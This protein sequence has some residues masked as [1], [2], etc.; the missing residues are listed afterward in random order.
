LTSAVVRIA[1]PELQRYL[2]RYPFA[3]GPNEEL[4]KQSLAVFKDSAE[5]HRSTEGEPGI[6]AAD[7]TSDSAWVGRATELLRL[8][9]PK[10]NVVSE[11]LTEYTWKVRGIPAGA[12][13]IL[14]IGCGDGCELAVIRAMFPD[15]S[16]DAIDWECKVAPGVQERLQVK[17]EQA[18]FIERL[19][20]ESRSYDAIFSNHVLEHMYDPET[21]LRGLLAWLSPGGAL[22]SAM[23]LDG[24]PDA[25]FAEAVAQALRTP[26][27]VS[28]IDLSWI[29][30]GHPWKA[31]P[32]SLRQILSA[33]GYQNIRLFERP[34][35]L[36]RFIVGNAARLRQVKRLGLLCDAATFA[37]P[38][39]ALRMWSWPPY[40]V[41]RVFFAAESRAWFS[42]GR[43]KNL[44]AP[45]ILF[46]AERPAN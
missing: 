39:A 15:A 16:I 43:L 13:R 21:T 9:R 45:E 42:R 33:A 38:R 20:S 3:T 32:I 18:S 10:Q 44:L 35:N 8:C 5:L 7:E 37:L 28:P 41:R 6:T 14:S 31:S 4:N 40:I 17:F 23:P 11:L 1:D 24:A 30:L 19:K 34:Q 29:D 46:R 22:V 27:N 36:S 26:Y 12:R 25:P 2:Q